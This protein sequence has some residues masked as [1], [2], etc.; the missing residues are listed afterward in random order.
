MSAY[1][2]KFDETTNMPFSIKK[3]EDLLRKYNEI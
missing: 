3:N 1:R 2:K